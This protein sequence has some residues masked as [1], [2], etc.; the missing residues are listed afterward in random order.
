MGAKEYSVSSNALR[1]IVATI[2]VAFLL[3]LAGCS[4]GL[5]SSPTTSSAGD[6]L[7]DTLPAE[8][9]VE[10]HFI[11]VG[12]SVSTLI[13]GPTGETMLV[14]TGHYRDDGEHVLQYLERHDINRID[15]LVTS[16]NDAD[17][18]GGN[19][20]IIEYYETE[21]DGIG[22]VYDPGIAASTQTY[23]EYLD[24][25]EEYDVTLYETREGDTIQIGRAH[26]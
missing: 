9:I 22:A 1:T 24:A 6:N 16:H 2:T 13:I 7:S 5:D 23:A 12:Q 26:V 17:H 18:I 20:A 11:N 25:V 19:A 8:G 10:V 3:V 14:D 15:Y 21:A 4:T